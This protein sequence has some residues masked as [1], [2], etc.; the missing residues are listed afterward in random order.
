MPCDCIH[1]FAF[2]RL[3]VL[4]FLR[5]EVIK[6]MFFCI[7]RFFFFAYFPKDLPPEKIRWCWHCVR[8][9]RIPG[10]WPSC[11]TFG[12]TSRFDES[13]IRWHVRCAP[14]TPEG[15]GCPKVDGHR[16]AEEYVLQGCTWD[17]TN[18][19]GQGSCDFAE[20][21]SGIVI[22]HRLQERRRSCRGGVWTYQQREL[23]GQ[24]RVHPKR[25]QR[26]R[27]GACDLSSSWW[28]VP[29]LW[30]CT[31]AQ[32]SI[33]Q[34]GQIVVHWHVAQKK[35]CS[36]LQVQKTTSWPKVPAQAHEYQQGRAV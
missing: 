6:K 32:P 1:F 20:Q 33:L 31:Q 25:P 3:C 15:C 14:C 24:G 36:Y 28:H 5:F 8:A 13:R 30:I 23:Q 27:R 35:P 26:K 21:D 4:I 2:F 7:L 12:V 16:S 11:H 18:S 19:I 29:F 22:L 9:A 17:I 10:L 34:E